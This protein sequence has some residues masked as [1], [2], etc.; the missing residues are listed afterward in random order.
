ME[1]FANVKWDNSYS[2]IFTLANGVRQGGVISA[3]LYCFY[4]NVLFYSLKRSGYGCWINGQYHGI[5]GYSDDNLLLAPSVFSL[6]NML[7]VCENFAE[8]HGLQF[9]TDA[10]PNK[11]KTKCVAFTAKKRPIL[12][13]INLCGNILP[14]VNQIKHLGN[15]ISNQNCLTD[16]D[17]DIKKAQYVTKNCELNQ[18]F[19][20]ASSRT[21][22]EL[23]QIYNSHFT[24]SPL[25]NLF[26]KS[27]IGLES[28]YNMSVKIM[29]DL[30]LATHRNLIVPVSGHVHLR[31]TLM[32]RSLSFIHQIEKSS[33]KTTKLLLNH[34]KYDARSLTGNNLRKMLLL[35]NR[36]NIDQ[37]RRAD[38]LN[39]EYYPLAPEVKWKEPM[40]CELIEC[41]EDNLEIANHTIEEINDIIDDLCIN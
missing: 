22:C 35:T 30:P 20:F 6:Q 32:A 39:I 28:S 7:K 13:N 37:L 5:F 26:G 36:T 9:S 2:E 14:W 31:N 17:I 38:I 33:K 23:N 34:I 18:E 4:S 11:C 29:F 41:R 8:E 1:Q 16:I 10:N 3:I 15:T 24:G 40:L 19:H 25:W 21:K 12:E 27:A